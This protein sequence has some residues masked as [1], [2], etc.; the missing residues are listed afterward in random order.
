MPELDMKLRIPLLT[1]LIL[2][3]AALPAVTSCSNDFE[4]SLPRRDQINFPI[5]IEFHPNGRFF[6]VVN[7]N[8]N[9]RF[10]PEAGGTVSV[11]DADT[12]ELRDQSTP[13]LPS[14]GAFVELNDDATK[15]YVT[16]RRNDA[17]V[18]YDVA[19]DGGA[20]FCSVGSGD[21]AVA[22]SDPAECILDRIPDTSE[23]ADLPPDPFGLAVFTIE[24]DDLLVDVVNTG[25]LAS[26]RVASISLPGRD[27][28][29]ATVQT[30]PLLSGANAV[31]QRPGTQNLY[32]AGRNT[33]GVAIFQPFVNDDGVVE[34]ILQRGSFTLNERSEAV[35]ARGMAFDERGDRLFIVSQRPDALHIVKI[36]PADPD[37]GAGTE[38]QVVSSIPLPDDPTDVVLHTTPQGRRLAYVSSFEDESIQVLD[39]DSEAIIDEIELDASPYEIVIE[40]PTSGCNTPEQ[41]C[42][43]FV[44]L[45]DDTEN[46]ADSCS[47][48]ETGCGSVAVIDINPLN[49]DPDN[50]ELSR[51]HTVITKIQ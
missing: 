36:V 31:A 28:S 50:P 20:L 47:D 29:S 42:R 39:I 3:L 6:Y 2:L 8:F 30:A 43:A 49:R 38:H 37:T 34:A 40:P 18:V 41:R 35:D 32:V 1:T 11:I 45:F 7:S 48:E 24:R 21:D 23:G 5:G 26:T 16:T 9:A 15:A 51:Y 4:G 12:L 44:T 27:L 46:V 10:R 17:V 19:A 25:H 33:N 22:T 14:F 13:Y